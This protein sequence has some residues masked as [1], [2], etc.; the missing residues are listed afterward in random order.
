[1][2]ADLNVFDPA[3]ILPSLPEVRRD[4]PGNG[5]RLTQKCQGILATIVSG[6][7]L[8]LNGEHTGAL[9]GKLLR[10]SLAK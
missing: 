3:R 9:P 8:L 1:M 4:L 2:V 6:Q 7:V 10:G 5:L